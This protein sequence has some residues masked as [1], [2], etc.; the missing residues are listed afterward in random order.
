MHF[1]CPTCKSAVEEQA[2]SYRCGACDRHYPVICGIPDFRLFPDPY[3]GIEEDR[4]KALHL[5]QACESRN[6]K[7]MI[8]YYYSITKKDDP[9]DLAVHFAA[10]AMAEVE[11]AAFLLEEAG[12]CTGHTL[13]DIG[14]ST[15][16]LLIAAEPH[17]S[18]LV[19]VDVALRWLVIG[20]VRLRENGVS[21]NLVCA[22]AEALPFADGSFDVITGSDVI[23]HLRDVPAALAES[24]RA[25]AP[26]AVFVWTT[27]NR[28]A[29]LPDPQVRMWGVGWLPRA[30]QAKYVSLRRKDLH[31]YHVRMRSV[32]ELRRLLAKAG[33]RHI[34]AE[35]APLIA[36]HRPNLERP[37]HLYNRVRALEGF[38]QVTSV[39][40]PRLW[41]LARH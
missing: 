27:A 13:L 21:A 23:E 39:I 32:W 20:A 19:G 10:H 26:D 6:F 22:N 11:I 9:P 25:A 18:E 3:I 33:Y 15:G 38:R 4:E 7:A 40:G 14:C 17:V 30:W 36:P 37:L 29:P 41:A 8:D 31:Y 2:H 12:I 16:G 5:H 35:A 24:Y 28:Y 34:V 1:V